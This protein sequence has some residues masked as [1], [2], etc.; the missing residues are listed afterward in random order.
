[1]ADRALALQ[2]LG[3]PADEAAAWSALLGAYPASVHA[4]R[5][6]RRLAELEGR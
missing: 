4:D 1:M 6:R 3:R 2:R 5:A